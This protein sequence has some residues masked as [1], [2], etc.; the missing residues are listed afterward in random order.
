ML[1]TQQGLLLTVVAV[2]HF[3]QIVFLFIA[4]KSWAWLSDFTFTFDF[5]ALEKE[6]ATHSDV[7]AWRIPGMAE[8][9]GLPSMGSHRVGHDWS[10]LAAAAAVFWL[11]S[12]QSWLNRHCL[13]LGIWFD[14]SWYQENKLCQFCASLG[15]TCACSPGPASWVQDFYKNCWKLLSTSRWFVR[16]R[17]DNIIRKPVQRGLIEILL[18]TWKRSQSVP[19]YS[20]VSFLGTL[21]LHMCVW[22]VEMWT[23][24]G[25]NLSSFLNRR[26]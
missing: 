6:M 7:L 3:F 10:D 2:N 26:T 8:P 21:C 5:H 4:S 19:P 23:D 22:L 1:A 18:K 13:Y 15:L 16:L 11:T 20:Q 14:K 17:P 24:W 25:A 9:G 12:C